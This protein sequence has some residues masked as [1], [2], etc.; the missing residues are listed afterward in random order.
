MRGT[1]WT[2]KLFTPTQSIALRPFTSLYIVHLIWQLTQISSEVSQRLLFSFIFIFS[3]VHFFT[4]NCDNY[5]L[6]SIS[7]N[8]LDIYY[9]ISFRLAILEEK[10]DM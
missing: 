3:F 7:C 1:I 5:N 6:S 8:R 2:V 9:W 10:L 4:L